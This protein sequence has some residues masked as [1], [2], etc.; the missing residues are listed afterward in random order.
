LR[1]SDESDI[2][3]KRAVEVNPD[4][5]MFFFVLCP[6]R[7]DSRSIKKNLKAKQP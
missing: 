2:Y 7:L 3:I 5:R 4:R 1:E 6:K